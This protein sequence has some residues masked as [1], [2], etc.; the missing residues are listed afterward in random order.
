MSCLLGLALGCG[1]LALGP[2][3][4]WLDVERKVVVA[5]GYTVPDGASH[6][7]LRDRGTGDVRATWTRSDVPQAELDRIEA[8]L[9]SDPG[10]IAGDPPADWPRFSSL[11]WSEPQWWKA[12]SSAGTEARVFHRQREQA[13]TLWILESGR[14]YTLLWS[15]EGFGA[16]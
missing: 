16:P 15:W 5:A 11:G 14:L 13:G 1:A 7:Y 12:T 8:R 6:V 4:E 10:V 9:R 2:D 3:A